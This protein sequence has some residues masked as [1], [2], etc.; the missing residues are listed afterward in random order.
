MKKTLLFILII[1]GIQNLNAQCNGRYETE[2]FTTVSKTTVNY[3]DVYTG[4]DHEMDIYT[5]DADTESNRPVI[6]FMHGGIFFNGD[7]GS[8]DCIDFCESFAKKGYVAIS[9]NYRLANFL[10]FLISQEVQF[11]TVLQ[12]IADIK[13]AIR[14]MHKDF[15]NGDNYGI[16]TSAIFAGGYSAGAIIAIHLAYIDKISD[17]PT[18][19]I[20]VQALIDSIGGTLDGDAGND[21]YASDIKGVVSFAGGINDLS[22]LDANDEPLF[23]T[24]GTLDITVPFD[25]G[26]ALGNPSILNLCGANEMFP[27]ATNVGV[28]VDTLVFQGVGHGWPAAG[29]TD[30]LFV[31]A[32]EFSSDF[33]YTLLPCY[34]GQLINVENVQEL[35]FNIYPNPA[36][37]VINFTSNQSVFVSVLSV[38]GKLISSNRI[39]ANGA[40]ELN[41]LASGMY[42]IKVIATDSMTTKKLMVN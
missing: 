17:L 27:Q 31:E 1:F 28:R 24:H 10:S 35:D 2:I 39:E 19:P 25:C 15:A 37:S 34:D 21:G 42:I 29:N 23:A 4:I 36:N 20:N 33:V 12:A 9:A 38:S 7:K 14:Y 22:L 40:L 11:K 30:P 32:L 13:S 16:D 5:P 41:N 8:F 6:F 18:S 26:P 3:S